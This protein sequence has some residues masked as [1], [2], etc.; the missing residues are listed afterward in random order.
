[1]Y[2]LIIFI[3]Y[4]ILTFIW[5]HG[6][7]PSILQYMEG[8]SSLLTSI[9][10]PSFT[11]CFLRAKKSDGSWHDLNLYKPFPAGSGFQ[12][13]LDPLVYSH[14]TTLAPL[15]LFSP[16]I[17]QHWPVKT[18]LIKTP[19]LHFWNCHLWFHLL[20]TSQTINLSPCF[21]VLAGISRAFPEKLLMTTALF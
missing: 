18:D 19:C 3:L 9:Y 7:H 12:I 17:S 16:A 13:W 4:N 11:F 2:K 5:N 1:M 21:L 6:W 14:W 20:F 15:S 8:F 10:A